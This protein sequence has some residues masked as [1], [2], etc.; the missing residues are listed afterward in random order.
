MWAGVA[1]ADRRVPRRGR[2]AG[3]VDQNLP[4]RQQEGFEAIVGL[5]A[6]AM[7]TY[8]IVYMR[9]HAREMGGELR[10]GAARAIAVGSAWSLIAMAFLAVMR[11]GLETALFLLEEVDRSLYLP[12]RFRLQ[13]FWLVHVI[14]QRERQ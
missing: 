6:V 2:R 7:V 10:G 14:R 13:S 3:V 5:I 4:Q 1:L 8:M 11:E 12:R 9:R